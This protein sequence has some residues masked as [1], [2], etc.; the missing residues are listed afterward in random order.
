[1]SGYSSYVIRIYRKKG[2]EALVG[3]IMDVGSGRKRTFN[4]A[5]GLKSAVTRMIE[6]PEL[7]PMAKSDK[8]K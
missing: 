1:M 8:K 3:Q 7:K 2:R 5:D 6:I 4:T